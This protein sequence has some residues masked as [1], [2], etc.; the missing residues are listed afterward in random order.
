ML[1]NYFKIFHILS[2]ALLLTSIV[3]C[4][5]LWRNMQPNQMNAIASRIQNQTW[6]IIIPAA[7]IQLASGFTMISLNH[8]DISET[9]LS[10]SIIGFIG[11]IGSWFGFIYFLLLAQQ[12]VTDDHQTTQQIILKYQFFRKIQSVMLVI[13]ALAILSLVFFMANKV[14]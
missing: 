11:V 5:K 6:M 8:Y 1:Y 10:G 14:T 4:Y 13:C 7:I 12:L 3:H 9:W 2:A